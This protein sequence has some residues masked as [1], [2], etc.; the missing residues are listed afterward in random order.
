MSRRQHRARVQPVVQ[1]R[2][3]SIGR[4]QDVRQAE[5]DHEPADGLPGRRRAINS[6]RPTKVSTTTS[7]TVM[8]SANSW[9]PKA[10]S[11]TLA[12]ASAS[13]SPPR[14]AVSRPGH[15]QRLRDGP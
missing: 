10:D 4:A 14:T 11:M 13:T 5:R 3:V 8:L 6:P 9:L 15:N 12:A 2:I 7:P 1:R